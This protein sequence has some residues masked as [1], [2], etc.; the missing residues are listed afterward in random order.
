MSTRHKAL[1]KITRVDLQALCDEEVRESFDIEYKRSLP[2]QGKEKINFLAA[3]SS[4]A[5]TRG[6]DLVLGIREEEGVAKELLGLDVADLDAEILKFE[7]LIRDC[8]KPRV[9]GV[10]IWPV[11]LAESRFALIVRAPRSWAAP[12]VVAFEEHWRFYA[13]NSAGKYQLDVD[14]LRAAFS[15]SEATSEKIRA[16]RIQRVNRV[17][18]GDTG[19]PVAQI[20][21]PKFILHIIPFGAFDIGQRF[22][23]SQLPNDLNAVAGIYEYRDYRFNLDGLLYYNVSADSYSRAFTQFY[24][25]GIIETVLPLYVGGT[26]RLELVAFEQ[27]LIKEVVPELLEVQK[28]LGA[29]PPIVLMISM[30]GVSGYQIW[31]YSVRGPHH[32]VH[33]ID[34]DPLII[35][36][37]LVEDFDEDATVFMRPIFNAIWNAAGW[38]MAMTYD[39]TGK[40][41]GKWP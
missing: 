23:L 40:W 37:T 15:L 18:S 39:E 21:E 28:R 19:V 8:I 32:P 14:Q 3:V 26:N 20:V 27:H 9:T 11:R 12:H 24:T 1:E 7:N 2:K 6:G 25:N 34:R 4:F 17:Q 36:E 22:D 35:P 31:P 10:Q 13:R 5:N 29:A 30:L 38:P 41:T 33:G 16:F